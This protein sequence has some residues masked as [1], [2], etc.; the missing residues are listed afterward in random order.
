MGESLDEKLAR[1][2]AEDVEVVEYDPAWPARFAAESDRLRSL[3]PPGTILRIEHFG[4]TAVPGLAAKPIIDILVS[5]DEPER[6]RDEVAP[7]LEAAGYDFWRPA[8]G[9]DGPRYPWFIA[10]DDAGRRTA[11]VHFAPPDDEQW[12]R[13]GFRDDL[14]RTRTSRRATRGSRARAPGA[15][16]TTARH[17]RPPR[18]RSSRPTRRTSPGETRV[19]R[20]PERPVVGI[21]GTP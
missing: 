4:S 5:V 21:P 11:H 9:D 10:R 14:R 17:T 6:V 19:E 15:T 2:L 20:P 16:G 13:V 7:R 1:V 3:L 8:F 18:R 12:R